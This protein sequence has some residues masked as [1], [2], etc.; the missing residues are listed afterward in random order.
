VDGKWHIGCDIDEREAEFSC[1]VILDSG[2]EMKTDRIKLIAIIL[3]AIP[4]LLLVTLKEAPVMSAAAP[5]DDA[6]AAYK[7]KCAACHTPTA[8]KF[9]DPTHTE[10]SQVQTILKG[11]KGEKPPYMPAFGEKGMT[12][13]EAKTLAAYMKTLKPAS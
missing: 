2:V 8:S 7:A 12:E 9:F 3:F 11:K 1:F 6:A 5:Y 13:D 4:L 10:E